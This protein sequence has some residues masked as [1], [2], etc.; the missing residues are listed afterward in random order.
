MPMNIRFDLTIKQSN[1]TL[2]EVEGVK[3]VSTDN[4]SKADLDRVLQLEQ[5]LE[6]L[7]GLRFHINTSVVEEP[8]KR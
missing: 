3:T 8:V 7:T 4:L 1:K 2:A 5:E 6:K